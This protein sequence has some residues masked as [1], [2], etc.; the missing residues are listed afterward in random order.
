MDYATISTGIA[1]SVFSKAFFS[2]N[3]DKVCV[4]RPRM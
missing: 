1:P 4:G 3:L 2:Q